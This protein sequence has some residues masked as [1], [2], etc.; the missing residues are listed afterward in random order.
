V[1]GTHLAHKKAQPKLTVRP[2]DRQSERMPNLKAHHGQLMLPDG[3]DHVTFL[4]GWFIAV[5]SGLEPALLDLPREAVPPYEALLRE[6]GAANSPIYGTVPGDF[7][8]SLTQITPEGLSSERWTIWNL[9]TRWQDKYFLP[10]IWCRRQAIQFIE[11]EAL[12]AILHNRGRRDRTI[13]TKGNPVSVEAGSSLRLKRVLTTGNTPA[14]YL[15]VREETTAPE[16]WPEYQPLNRKRKAYL[17]YIRLAI[18]T[19]LEGNPFTS[20]NNAYFSKQVRR[21]FIKQVLAETVMPYCASVEEAY[22]RRGCTKV[23]DLPK[24][25]EHL[26]LTAKARLMGD[27]VEWEDLARANGMR[28]GKV[29]ENEMSRIRKAVRKTLQVLDLP[30][31]P[32]F[33]SQRG[34]PR[35]S[36]KTR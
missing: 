24:T 9:L 32:T 23:S 36:A 26:Y 29:L 4:R 18:D 3:Q 25:E 31:A 30:L 5:L 17:E 13:V 20:A 6:A 35:R 19:H 34:A 16:G 2:P 33:R 15:A 8:S 10:A 12:T 7:D 22:L 1:V 14:E 28:Y 21:D 11:N 27:H